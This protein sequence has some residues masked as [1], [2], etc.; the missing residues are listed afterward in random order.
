[1]IYSLIG[2]CPENLKGPRTT[3]G[4]ISSTTVLFSDGDVTEYKAVIFID[5]NRKELKDVQKH[6][7]ISMQGSSS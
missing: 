1:M 3:V 6:G 4:E 2:L 5:V 7:I